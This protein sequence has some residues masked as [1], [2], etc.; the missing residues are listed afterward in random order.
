MQGFAPALPTFIS[1]VRHDPV[2]CLTRFLC[3]PT[4]SFSRDGKTLRWIFAFAPSVC[5]GEDRIRVGTLRVARI[6]PALG[7]APAATTYSELNGGL[8]PNAN[9]SRQLIRKPPAQPKIKTFRNHAPARMSAK[10][11]AFAHVFTRPHLKSRTRPCVRLPK[12][13]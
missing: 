11:A 1:T 9:D 2:Y 13:A 3:Y 7:S 8:K 4:A 12:C 10:A 6:E 5:R